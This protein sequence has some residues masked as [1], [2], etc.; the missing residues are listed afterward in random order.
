MAATVTIDADDLGYVTELARQLLL[1]LGMSPVL[2]DDDDVDVAW[3]PVFRAFLTLEYQAP[4]TFAHHY[5]LWG[6]VD[7]DDDRGGVS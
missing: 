7:E 2:N 5:A 1:K 3:R 6:G 4:Q